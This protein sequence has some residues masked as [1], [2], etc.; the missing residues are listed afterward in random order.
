MKVGDLV[1]VITR[2]GNEELG[3]IMVVRYSVGTGFVYEVR[4][5][6]SQ[7][8]VVATKEMLTVISSA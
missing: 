3:L 2:S 7:T 4:C 1:R 8:E 6:E 5:Q